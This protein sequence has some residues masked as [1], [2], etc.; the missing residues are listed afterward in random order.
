MD[1]PGAYLNAELKEP[2][3]VRFGA[4]L[5][6]EYTNLYPKYKH[7]S[8]LL[9]IVKKAFYGLPES[10]ALWYEVISKFLL[11]LGYVTHPCDKGLF[12]CTDLKDSKR[13]C[14]LSLWVDDIL[15]WATHDSLIRN[16][17]RTVMKKYGDARLDAGNELQYI[18]MVITQPT[19]GVIYVSQH[20]YTRKIIETTGITGQGKQSKSL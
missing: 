14:V 4:D 20:E 2:H 10:S 18:C 8:T 12:V 3:M 17:E 7:I 1:I 16:L 19:S 11:D 15:G 9:L 6:E 5:A 13:S